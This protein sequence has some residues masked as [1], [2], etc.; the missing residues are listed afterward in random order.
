MRDEPELE[1]HK[2]SLRC[3][4]EVTVQMPSPQLDTE[5]GIQE[6]PGLDIHL[7]E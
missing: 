3:Q 2:L 1:W 4:V 6:G 5:F 7:W